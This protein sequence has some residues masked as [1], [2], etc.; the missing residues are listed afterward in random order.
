MKLV[1]VCPVCDTE[2]PPEQ[3]HCLACASLLADVDFVP[4]RQ[5]KPVE[6][7]PAREDKAASSEIP[8]VSTKV[9][10]RESSPAESSPNEI[11]A[12]KTFA[13]EI[14]SGQT[15][16]ETP[17][18]P[19]IVDEKPI[20][21]DSAPTMPANKAHA[22]KTPTHEI[23]DELLADAEFM[24][25]ATDSLIISNIM[26]SVEEP[27]DEIEGEVRVCPNP[28]CG[29]ANPAEAKRC[30]YCDTPL[31]AEPEQEE[32]PRPQE[33]PEEKQEE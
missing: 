31:N 14:S 12:S 33:A 10:A 29:Q 27:E 28:D 11:P 16:S 13:S 30:L 2:N 5:T 25:G 17:A 1:R 15:S 22:S 3:V 23:P 18:K 21:E 6:E 9:S 4:A 19:L 8:E 7:I 32:E 20:A 24:A 26:F